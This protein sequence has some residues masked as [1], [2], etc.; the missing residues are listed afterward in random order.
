META[1][2]RVLAVGGGEVKVL[3]PYLQELPYRVEWAQDGLTAG[4]LTRRLKF[5]YLLV[6]YPLPDLALGDF[7]AELRRPESASATA[8]MLLVTTTALLPEV[9]AI[10]DEGFIIGTIA[11]DEPDVDLPAVLAE[12]MKTAARVAIRIPARVVLV[13]GSG[14]AIRGETVNLSESG[15]LV[16]S[17]VTLD[18]GAEV[19]VELRP[20]RTHPIRARAAVVR[21]PDLECEQISGMGLRFV[22]FESDG[23]ELLN[24]LIRGLLAEVVG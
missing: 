14:Q 11:V 16:R 7:L 1:R 21:K 8:R 22:E 13:G 18:H 20:R 24:L 4:L 6:G 2:E 23:R 15:V 10:Q 19:D 9:Q 17:A 12:F 5:Q 3:A